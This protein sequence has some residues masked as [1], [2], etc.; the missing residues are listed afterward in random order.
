MF[1]ITRSS[2]IKVGLETEYTILDHRRET[3]SNDFL[4]VD[5][6]HQS[7]LSRLLIYRLRYTLSWQ[8]ICKENSTFCRRWHLRV[9]MQCHWHCKTIKLPTIVDTVESKFLSIIHTLQRKIWQFR[10]VTDNAE[11]KIW[12][13]SK[14]ALWVY[15][16]S[17][18][19]NYI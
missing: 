18:V 6:F 3:V 9:T 17:R 7:I 10:G 1:E 8:G 13:I 2:N 4:S 19:K 15:R 12:I 5:I 14:G 16:T 11:S